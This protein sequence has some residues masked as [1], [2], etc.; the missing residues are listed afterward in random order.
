MKSKIRVAVVFG[1]R[2]AEHEVSLQSALSIIAALDSDRY[3]IVPIGIDTGGKWH[4]LDPEHFVNAPENPSRI[5]LGKSVHELSLVPGEDRSAMLRGAQN[6]PAI[7]VVFPVLHGTYG[8]DGSIQGLLRMLDVPFVGSSILGSALG[9]DKEMTKRLF[10]EAGLPTPRYMVLRAGEPLDQGGVE[11]T[12][13]W[14]VFV[15]P[16][17]MGSSVGVTKVH[18]AADLR[19]AAANAFEYDRK[20][21]IEEAIEG[22]ELECSVLGNDSPR[23]SVVGEVVPQHHEFYSYEAKYLDEHGATL[24]IPARL[25]AP[26][27]D[28]VRDLAVKAFGALC[29]SGMARV[30]FFLRGGEVLLN[31]VNTIPG[32]TQISMYPKLWEATGMPYPELLNELIRLAI[33]RHEHESRLRTRYMSGVRS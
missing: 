17:N 7:D 26:I 20:I 32:F 25:D 4:V 12:L 16:A 21:L 13:G 27:V 3:D 23:A 14:P 8:E 28:R 15:K 30:D 2:S 11:R 9:M 33:E 22:R 19:E 10:T 29:L 6:L 31:E 24:I 1:G 5:S 18:S